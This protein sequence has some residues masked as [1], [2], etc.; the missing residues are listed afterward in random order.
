MFKKYDYSHIISSNDQ[1]EAIS[2][3]YNLIKTGNWCKSVPKFQTYSDIHKYSEL[4]IF[5]KTFLQSCYDYLNINY[6]AKILMWCYKDNIFNIKKKNLWH[7][8]CDISWG[9]NKISGIYYL[10]NPL[11]EG[12]K[13]QN[14]TLE[15]NPYTWYIYPSNLLHRPP[16]TKSFVNRYTLAADFYY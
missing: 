8:H 3:V 14:F 12:T 5:K 9:E 4:D 11:K 6:N 1:K 7:S 15:A 13:F 16:N 10:K 2:L